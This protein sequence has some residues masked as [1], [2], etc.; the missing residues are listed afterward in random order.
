MQT[1]TTG[2]W[3]DGIAMGGACGWNECFNEWKS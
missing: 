1:E 2:Q 3:L